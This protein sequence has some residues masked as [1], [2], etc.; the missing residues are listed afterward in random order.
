LAAK[1][2]AFEGHGQAFRLDGG[3]VFELE[4]L[5]SGQDL[6]GELEFGEAG[7]AFDRRNLYGGGK[8][9]GL[10][11]TALAFRPYGGGVL[12][13]DEF[14]LGP[15]GSA[16]LVEGRGFAPAAGTLAGAF[17]LAGVPGALLTGRT[18]I[19]LDGDFSGTSLGLRWIFGV[20]AFRR[21]LILA[22]I[23]KSLPTLLPMSRNTCDNLTLLWEG[24]FDGFMKSGIDAVAVV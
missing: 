23:L 10:S 21:R 2:C 16:L 3:A 14:A 17:S 18:G 22:L 1:S 13:G 8:R 6:G 5:H 15:L 19:C 20:K 9:Q 24:F 4:I 11:L 12:L 7:L